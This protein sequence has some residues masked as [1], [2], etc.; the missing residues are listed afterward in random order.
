[1]TAIIM[2]YYVET[3]VCLIDW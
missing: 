2:K 1:M 3:T